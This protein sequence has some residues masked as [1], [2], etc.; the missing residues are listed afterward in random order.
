MP[1]GAK[2]D[3]FSPGKFGGVVS[4]QRL[5]EDCQTTRYNQVVSI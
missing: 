3:D 4:T 5:D 2:V 1:V